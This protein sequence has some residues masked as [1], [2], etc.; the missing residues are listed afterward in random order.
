MKPFRAPKHSEGE[1]ISPALPDRFEV[2]DLDRLELCKEHM[3]ACSEREKEFLGSVDQRLK[4]KL[5]LSAAQDRWLKDIHSRFDPDPPAYI[6]VTQGLRGHFAVLIQRNED[7]DFEPYNTGIGSYASPIGAAIEGREWAMS[8]GIPFRGGKAL[9]D[10]ERAELAAT[11]AKKEPLPTV[12]SIVETTV[13]V[14]PQAA[15]STRFN[16]KR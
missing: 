4:S 7:G 16:F 3:G 13:E 11:A 15:S 12:E 8:E 14:T 9:E 1:A 10:A 2:T 5:T 6:S